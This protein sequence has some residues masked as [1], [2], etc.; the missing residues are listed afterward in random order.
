MDIENLTAFLEEFYSKIREDELLA[1]IFNNKV[2]NWDSHLSKVVI[3]WRHHLTE[4][5]LYKGNLL[6]VH[7]RLNEETKLKDELF[8]RWMQ[9]FEDSA[10]KYFSDTDLKKI[11]LKARMISGTIFGRLTGG[12]LEVPGYSY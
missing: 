1:D 8:Q 11:T 9:L 12:N 6:K 5:G 4:P 7:Q 2:S 3:F 10:Q